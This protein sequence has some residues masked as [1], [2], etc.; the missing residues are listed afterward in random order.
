VFI[1]GKNKDVFAGM[2]HRRLRVVVVFTVPP[3]NHT[4][5]A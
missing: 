1:T 4:G 2:L 3:R 5:S